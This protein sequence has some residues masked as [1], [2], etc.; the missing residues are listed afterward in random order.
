MMRHGDRAQRGPG[1]SILGDAHLRCMG[2][3]PAWFVPE[4]S[5]AWSRALTRALQTLLPTL[6]SGYRDA[7]RSLS[8][9]SLLVGHQQVIVGG[10][11]GIWPP[12]RTGLP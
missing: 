8:Q 12:N 3:W 4:L 6:V 1:A 10:P 7:S 5:L 11:R 9:H 2:P